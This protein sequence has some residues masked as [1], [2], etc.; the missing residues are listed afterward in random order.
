M[1]PWVTT[2]FVISIAMLYLVAS[3]I[4]SDI[5]Q[6]P[7][8]M[9]FVRILGM[10]EPDWID[11]GDGSYRPAYPLRWYEQLLWPLWLVPVIVMRLAGVPKRTTPTRDA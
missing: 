10:R 3:K 1:Q 4:V 2:L 5:S 7:F 11:R 9:Q 6:G 8:R